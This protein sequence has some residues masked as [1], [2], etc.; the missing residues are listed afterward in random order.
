V[1]ASEDIRIEQRGGLVVVTLNRPQALNALSYA[2]SRALHDGLARWRADPAVGAVLIKSAGERAFCAGGDLRWLYEVLTAQGV[3]AAL[4]F[5]T[6][7]Y[8]MNARLHHF[9]KPYVALLD[10][11]AM[12]GGVGISV[13]GSHRVVTERTVFAMPETGIGLFPD[14]GATYVLPRLHGALG[15][16]LG[17]TGARLN[18]ADCLWARIGS[19]HVPAD[20]LDALEDALAGADFAADA[21]GAVDRVL[22]RFGTPSGPAPLAQQSDRIDSAYGQRDLR[23]V[24]KALGDEKSGWG[25]AQLAQLSTK[26]PTSLA[27]TFRQ[28]REG[29]ALDFDDAMRL[30]YRLVPRFLAGHD[31][32]EGVRALIIDKDGRPRWRPSRL[33][34]VSPNDVEDYFRPLPAGELQLNGPAAG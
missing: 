25:E 9:S 34:E 29:A 5:Y 3:A 33:E 6:L 11:I 14:V 12:G 28:L 16:Y 32:R 7:E 13:H 30:E 23:A 1:R 18:A 4:P 17:L 26:S 20:R 31:F 21:H 10:G 8:A 22:A 2:M 27:V 24:L 15:M 19:C